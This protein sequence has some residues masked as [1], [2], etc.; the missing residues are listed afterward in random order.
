MIQVAK[1]KRCVPYYE[2][3]NIFGLSHKQVG[4]YAGKL[5]DFC[6]DKTWPALN[7]L[8]ISS[9]DCVPS[10]GFNWYQKK[11][12]KSWGEIISDCWK[13]FHVTG[14]RK[15]QVQDFSGLDTETDYFLNK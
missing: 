6:L 4:F 3:E 11:F 7:G 14:T 9:S 8:I 15:K 2:L 13:K 10:E 1:D 12:K 5:G